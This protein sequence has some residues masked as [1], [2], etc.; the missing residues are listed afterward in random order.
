MSEIKFKFLNG[1]LIKHYLN[2]ALNNCLE[3]E[4]IKIKNELELDYSIEHDYYKLL[5]DFEQHLKYIIKV[6]K[7]WKNETLSY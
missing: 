4:K 6:N 2:E 1:D 5:E 3:R 7:R